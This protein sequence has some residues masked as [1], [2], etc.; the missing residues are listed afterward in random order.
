MKKTLKKAALFA[1]AALMLTSVNAMATGNGDGNNGTGDGNGGDHQTTIVHPYRLVAEL[2]PVL[3]SGGDVDYE[4]TY[5]RAKEVATDLA[6]WIRDTDETEALGKEFDWQII[7]DMQE[8]PS[9]APIDPTGKLEGN[10]TV[11]VMEAYQDNYYGRALGTEPIVN[12]ELMELGEIHGPALPFSIAVSVTDEGMIQVITSECLSYFKI[13]WT[14]VLTGEQIEDQAFEEAVSTMFLD[15]RNDLSNIVWNALEANQDHYIQYQDSY[16][17]PSW[18]TAG[19]IIADITQLDNMSPYIH[20]TYSKADGTDFTA[21]EVNSLAASVVDAFGTDSSAT[22]YSGRTAPMVFPG[23]NNVI[24]ARSNDYETMLISDNRLDHA[25]ATPEQ[26]A[27]VA[28]NGG[29]DVQVTYLDPN[30][31]LSMMYKFSD[32][33]AEAIADSGVGDQMQAEMEAIVNAGLEGKGLSAPT[34]VYYDMIRLDLL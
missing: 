24:Q 29:A 28:I 20:Y 32:Q 34:Q 21:E 17:G 25:N 22:W 27:L 1:T 3:S 8:V 11:S 30:F 5:A 26:I 19:D 15:M 10:Q 31:M 23:D 12:G 6:A 14:D 18:E 9:L 16:T 2:E 7:G 4:K 33:E 13:F